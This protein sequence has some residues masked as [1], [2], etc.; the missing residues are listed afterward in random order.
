VAKKRSSGEG[1]VR[2]LP[3]GR[4]RGELMDGYTPEGKK[5]MVYFNGD[6]KSDVLE[7]IRDYLKL[8]EANVKVN[9]SLTL[10]EWADTWYADYK[11]QVQP[12][13]YSGYKYTLNVIK[14]LLGKYKLKDLLPVDVNSFLDTLYDMH[15]SQSMIKKCKA[16]LIQILDSAEANNLV[17]KNPARLSKKLRGGDDEWEES[18]KD[19]FTEEEIRLLEKNLPRDLLGHS[20]RL[21]LNTGMRVQELLALTPDSICEDGSKI[22]ID[23]AIKTV[24]GIPMVGPPK[25]K[26]SKRVIPVP[27]SHRDCAIFLREN[28]GKE[29]I[30]TGTLHQSIYGVGSFRRRYYTALSKIPGVRNLSPHCCRHTYVTRLE[31]R[32][33]PMEVIAR[34]AGH[35]EIK[36]TDHYLHTSEETLS[37]A[38][39]V[40]NHLKKKEN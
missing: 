39:S 24:N 29:L 25:S 27:E 40:L 19:A 33:V 3:S 1:C 20:I 22:Y 35:S 30:W 17:A 28:G 21:M 14:N 12:S 2:K 4:W 31:A 15:Y 10:E 37:N 16:M 18:E 36:T 23:R 5:C 7:Q 11:T 8:R 38:V 6:K 13:T 34:L 32:N 9:Q 26:R